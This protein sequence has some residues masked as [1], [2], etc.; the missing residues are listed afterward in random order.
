MDDMRSV[1][2]QGQPLADKLTRGKEP[3]RKGAPGPD[4]L[5]FAQLQAKAFFQLGMEFSIRKRDNSRGLARLFRPYNR[6][7]PAGQWQDRERACRQKVLFSSAIVLALML[8]RSHD[9][10]LIV[11]PSM[12]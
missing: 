1:A 6:A 2:N 12:R 10:R 11:I 7:A 3:E 8:D 4:H 5:E 9:R